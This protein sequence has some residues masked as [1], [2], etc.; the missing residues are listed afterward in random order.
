MCT[1]DD[2]YCQSM[3][4]YNYHICMYIIVCIYIQV[5]CRP[6]CNTV[7]MRYGKVMEG[8]VN[9]GTVMIALHETGL[10]SHDANVLYDG[11]GSLES[12]AKC[13]LQSVVE[14]TS[15]ET[16]TANHMI[17]FIHSSTNN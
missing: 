2:G 6:V 8:V 12:I 13:N 14:L 11:C 9:E 4:V 15:L 17:Q 5:T 3:Y 16:T 7:R 10:S 1:R